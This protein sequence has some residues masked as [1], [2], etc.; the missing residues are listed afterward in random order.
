VSA[1]ESVSQMKCHFIGQ[2]SSCADARRLIVSA[3][4][5]SLARGAR[6]LCGAIIGNQSGRAWD[7]RRR[8]LSQQRVT[9]S[10]AVR[11]YITYFLEHTS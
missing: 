4:V 3:F 8:T 1:E 5:A 7:T 9:R 11:R 2:I 10:R 6:R